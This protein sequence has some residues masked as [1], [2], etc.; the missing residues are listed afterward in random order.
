M[1]NYEARIARLEEEKSLLWEIIADLESWMF[2]E[3]CFVSSRTQVKID[4]ARAVVSY[5][6]EPP[7][8][9]PGRPAKAKQESEG[10]TL[11]K[12]K[13][14]AERCRVRMT[15]YWAGVRAEKRLAVRPSNKSSPKEE[16]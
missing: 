3:G 2:G 1:Q 5:V 15:K 10:W 14:A 6:D 11:E 13:A 4:M 16:A 8:R 12:R 9:K 7:K